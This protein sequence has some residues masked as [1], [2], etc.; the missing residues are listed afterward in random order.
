MNSLI[1]VHTGLM[2]GGVFYGTIRINGQD[3]N[4]SNLCEVGKKYR[5]RYTAKANAGFP[6]I[7]DTECNIEQL[8]LYLSKNTTVV[9]VER[10]ID[11]KSY[12]FNVLTTKSAKWNSIDKNLLESFDVGDMHRAFPKMIDWNIW[13]DMNT[14]FHTCKSFVNN[15]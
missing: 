7:G 12:W 2:S 11:G 3:V 4:V 13:K 10:L 14:K 15:K 5:F 6:I 1:K 8:P 9:Q